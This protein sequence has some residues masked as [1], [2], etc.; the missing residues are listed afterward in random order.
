MRLSALFLIAFVPALL[1]AQPTAPPADWEP[2]RFLVGEWVGV[3]GGDPGQGTGGFTFSLDLQNRVLVR[4]NFADYPETA[5][6]KAFRHDDLM[7]IYQ[8][9]EAARADYFD[10]EGHIIRYTVEI[11]KDNSAVFVSDSTAP[12]P[13]FRLTYTK[14]GPD[15][16]RIAFDIAPPGKPQ[17][18]AKYIEAVARRK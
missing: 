4:R 3:G 2:W 11:V 16:M 6:R 10:N 9:N 1:L 8:A 15:S 7:V 14:Q 17:V 18:F 13:R 12:G 5:E